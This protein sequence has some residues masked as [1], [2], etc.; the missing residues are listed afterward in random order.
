ML[1]PLSFAFIVILWLDV[2]FLATPSRYHVIFDEGK[3]K[4]SLLTVNTTLSPALRF[5]GVTLIRI[6]DNESVVDYPN[7]TEIFFRK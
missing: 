5:D 7:T 4:E 3:Y 1:L 2:S 6:D